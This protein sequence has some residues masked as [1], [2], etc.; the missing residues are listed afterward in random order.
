MLLRPRRTSATL[1][2]A[3]YED[4]GCPFVLNLADEWPSPEATLAANELRAVLI[5]A[6]SDLRQNLRIVLLLREFQRLTN[7]GTARRLGLSVTA[8]KT[9]I[10]HARRRLRLCL[11][12]KLKPATRPRAARIV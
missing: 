1:L 4:A 7:E 3:S 9:R 6:I 2:E 10:F 8:V 11:E 12:Q 5:Q